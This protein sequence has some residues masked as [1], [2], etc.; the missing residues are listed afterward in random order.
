MH[1]EIL[2]ICLKQNKNIFNIFL[3]LLLRIFS[4]LSSIQT[5]KVIGL[6]FFLSAGLEK[7]GY[8]HAFQAYT[9]SQRPISRGGGYT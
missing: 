4:T 1:V 9:Y 8:E 3:T 2:N 7:L 5:I 6:I